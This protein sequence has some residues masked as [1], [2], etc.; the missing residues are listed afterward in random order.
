MNN[1]TAKQQSDIID[2]WGENQFIKETHNEFR[3]TKL[4]QDEVMRKLKTIKNNITQMN[5][6]YADPI[7]KISHGTIE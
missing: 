1:D 2:T 4:S 3:F 5:I 7:K 6:I